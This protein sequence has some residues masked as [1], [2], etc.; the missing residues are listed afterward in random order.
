M[1]IEDNPLHILGLPWNVQRGQVAAQMAWYEEHESDQALLSRYRTAYQNIER[2]R[3][4]LPAWRRE[5]REEAQ[6]IADGEDRTLSEP[7]HIE[8][9]GVTGTDHSVEITNSG[10]FL[11]GV[12]RAGQNL[13]GRWRRRGEGHPQD[14]GV[15][16]QAEGDQTRTSDHE[17]N[18]LSSLL[19][20]I[21]SPEPA[22]RRYESPPPPEEA[23]SAPGNADE[24]KERESAQT[25][26]PYDQDEDGVSTG[27]RR[28][29]KR[30]LSRGS[31]NEIRRLRAELNQL[32]ED[33]DSEIL[34]ALRAQI[35]DRE[36]QRAHEAEMAATEERINK[37]VADVGRENLNLENR[38]AA[39]AHREKLASVSA[40]HYSSIL[41]DLH[42]L[43]EEKKTREKDLE[44]TAAR[45]EAA[46]VRELRESAKRRTD[47]EEAVQQTLKS[48][49]KEGTAGV[50][51]LLRHP[52]ITA[53]AKTEGKLKGGKISD[54]TIAEERANAEVN[55]SVEAGWGWKQ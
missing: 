4:N 48:N 54:A 39:L 45:E 52:F 47:A 36:D 12:R 21:P 46:W 6:R 28:F 8:S 29:F 16:A 10:R 9:T 41:S 5:V 15:I 27:S 11:S 35:Q 18:S 22:R 30:P 26:K 55:R 3:K 33:R 2:N 40:G 51:T 44:D 19:A 42:K 25:P 43:R 17:G 1:A 24:P 50:G 14:D 49:I 32:R 23:I 53:K 7:D 34:G 20:Q 38:E 31:R 13:L 37:A